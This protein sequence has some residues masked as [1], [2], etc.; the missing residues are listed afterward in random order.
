MIADPVAIPE[1][2]GLSSDRLARIE[3][4][5]E[6]FIDN[7]IIAGAVT[8]VARNGKIAHLGAHGH[9]DVAAGKTMRPNAIFRL[10]SMTKPVVGVAIMQ[11]LEDGKILL[12]DPISDF[13]PAFKNLQ[14]ALPN[15]AAPSYVS[16]T[17]PTGGYHLAPAEREVTVRDLLT[18]TSGLGSA[19][20]GR[21]WEEWTGLLQ[22]LQ[23]SNT[24]ADFVPRMA[25][26]SLSFQPG[27]A[28]EYSGIF[29]FDTLAHIVELVS[30]M[31]LERYFQQRIFEPLGMHDTTFH[32]PAAR[33]S[34][35]VTPYERGA[36]GLQPGTPTGLLSF[37]TV[38]DGRYCSGGG[39]LAG[40]AEDYARFAMALCAGGELDGARILARKTIQLMASN[41][42]GNLP[43]DRPTGDLR[44]YRFGLSV[45]VLQD[46]AEGRTMC[47]TGTFGWA[48]AYGTNSWI[49]PIEDTIGLMLIQRMPDM[50]DQRLR[51]LWP[52]YQ[53]TVYQALD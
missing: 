51:S 41:H 3:P 48:G 6:T 39:G 32:V 49:D 33:L 29:G 25:S 24:L 19:T 53:N 7:G 23:A 20:T 42:I 43:W 16:T 10:A 18:H 35:V 5:F 21:S 36:N 13:V 15:P 44:G 17:V 1:D 40:T 45:R 52:R 31:S 28:W 34:D 8:L 46:P 14:V 37:S 27:S 26:T 50:T 9:M 12:T 22:S 30:G 38:T 11:L 47:S 2:V 4:L